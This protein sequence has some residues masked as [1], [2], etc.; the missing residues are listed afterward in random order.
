[1]DATVV[2]VYNVGNDKMTVLRVFFNFVFY[3]DLGCKTLFSLHLFYHAFATEHL[4]E[5]IASFDPQKS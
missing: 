1:M 4:P 5:L 3:T 2:E